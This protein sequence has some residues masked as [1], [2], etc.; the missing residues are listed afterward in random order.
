MIGWL[1]ALAVIVLLA[2][3]PLGVQVRYDASGASVKIV[4]G[5][6]RVTL[7]PRRKKKRD[8][9]K[10]P[11]KEKR[12]AAQ[13]APAARAG[14]GSVRDFVP[15]LRVA[16]DFLGELR[17][18]L[19]IDRLELKLVLGGDDPADLAM[20]YGRAWE[21]LGSLWPLLARAFVIKKRDVQIECDF[22]SEQT[23][24]TARCRITIT[25]ARLLSLAVRYG[26]RALKQYLKI[27]N[28]RK[29]G[30]DHESEHSQYAGK[31]NRKDS[32]NGGC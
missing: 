27:K 29:G 17:R 23:R 25:L 30:T 16:L 1:I 3:L 10:K 32:G 15:L 26:V 18:K 20:L 12:P 24:V 22:T 13:A 5:P 6:V 19:R 11:K 14:G 7:L 21:A 31:H 2:L 9:P 28:N 8:K 4:A